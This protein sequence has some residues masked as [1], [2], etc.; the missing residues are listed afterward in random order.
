MRIILIRAAHRDHRA[1]RVV[2][3]REAVHVSG[4]I[5][6]L[7]R[8]RDARR[9]LDRTKAERQFALGEV[10]ECEGAFAESV[11]RQREVHVVATRALHELGVVR[12]P[13][14]RGLVDGEPRVERVQK[15]V[16]LVLREVLNPVSILF[17]ADMPV[18]VERRVVALLVVRHAAV[19][20][21]VAVHD[22][23]A[24]AVPRVRP[25]VERLVGRVRERERALL[26]VVLDLQ[27]SR[28]VVED[29]GDVGHDAHVRI[30]RR[31]E[32]RGEGNVRDGF[33]DRVELV[34]ADEPRRRVRRVR[35]VFLRDEMERELPADGV[36]GN[37]VVVAPRVVAHERHARHGPARLKQDFLHL[38]PRRLVRIGQLADQL[39]PLH[40][41]LAL[42]YAHEVVRAARRHPVHRP[43]RR[44]VRDG[45]DIFAP[46]WPPPK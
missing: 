23:A 13:A 14:V 33:L 30:A 5:L 12:R 20:H 36:R 15:L 11:Q 31:M 35:V 25:L 40:V 2:R 29:H 1:D 24:E 9:E 19:R 3:A 44:P 34:R 41:A 27:V 7:D 4:E 21:A 18:T 17:G 32:R 8:L 16:R 42:A 45:G 43:V 38:R 10:L 39:H 26:V 28:S 22:V 46:S 6:V 37:L